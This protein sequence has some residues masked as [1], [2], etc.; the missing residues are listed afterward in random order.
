MASPALGGGAFNLR[1]PIIP[2]D[3]HLSKTIWSV[4]HVNSRVTL[5]GVVFETRGDT[6]VEGK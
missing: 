6:D 5:I 2:R 1:D 4:K 3:S